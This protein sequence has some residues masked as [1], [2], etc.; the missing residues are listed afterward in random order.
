MVEYQQSEQSITNDYAVVCSKDILV[1]TAIEFGV[2]SF[3]ASS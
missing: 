2:T 3:V 1:L